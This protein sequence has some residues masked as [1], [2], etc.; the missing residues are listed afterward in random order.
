MAG[1]LSYA[2]ICPSCHR[3]QS[4]KVTE[5]LPLA[6]FDVLQDPKLITFIQVREAVGGPGKAVKG[7]AA[8][9]TKA[10]GFPTIA[11]LSLK[12]SYESLEH[13]ERVEALYRSMKKTVDYLESIGVR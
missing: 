9:G 2:I 6:W 12:E 5:E 11:H 1:K 13:R 3:H 8:Y 4:V 10:V 7:K